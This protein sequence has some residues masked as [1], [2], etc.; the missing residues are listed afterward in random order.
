M[1]LLLHIQAPDAPPTDLER[2]LRSRLIIG[3]APACDVVLTDRRVSN[4]HLLLDLVEGRLYAMD[5]ES[6]NGTRLRRGPSE[7]ALAPRTPTAL[8]AGDVLR[9]GRVELGLRI[10]GDDE[11]APTQEMV[12]PDPVSEL[13][14]SDLIEE[15]DEPGGMDALRARR[16]GLRARLSAQEA[17]ER[18]A[19][20]SEASA[21]QARL[22]EG[23]A[24]LESAQRATAEA[25]R[26]IETLVAQAGS[27][28]Q[29]ADRLEA[30]RQSLEAAADA[31]MERALRLE[32]RLEQ[33]RLEVAEARKRLAELQQVVP[34]LQARH[35]TLAERH[36]DEVARAA[37]RRR[38]G[39]SS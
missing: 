30:E 25:N 17:E 13:D 2:D 18:L 28:R 32:A 7:Q 1:R 39:G 4:R 15:I 37:A 5:L 23:Q 16:D 14:P 8:Q 27:R 31:A 10:E 34:A 3:R 9:V 29:E 36:R 20:D 33:V 38:P 6:A 12:I 21:L 22:A 11:P 35:A 24:R 26:Q 19:V